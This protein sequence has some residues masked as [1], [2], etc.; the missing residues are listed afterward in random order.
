MGVVRTREYDYRH[1][2][3]VVRAWQWVSNVMLSVDVSEW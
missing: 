2:I 1:S 3:V